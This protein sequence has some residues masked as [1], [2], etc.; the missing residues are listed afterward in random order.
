LAPRFLLLH[1]LGKGWANHF[2]CPHQEG[3]KTHP[4][5]VSSQSERKRMAL[6]QTIL[7]FN[8]SKIV[9]ANN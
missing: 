4:A 5:E 6:N 2:H 9:A 3:S 8:H 7:V 1:G